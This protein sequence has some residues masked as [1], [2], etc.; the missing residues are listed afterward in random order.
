MKYISE[1][2]LRSLYLLIV[3]MLAGCDYLNEEPLHYLQPGERF[4]EESQME[5]AVHECYYYLPNGYNDVDGSFLDAATNDAVYRI[6]GSGINKLARGEYTSST[7][8]LNIWDR[9]YKGISQTFLVED[10]LHYMNIPKGSSVSDPDVYFETKRKEF[11]SE[12]MMVRAYL[13]FELLRMYGGVP[14]VKRQMELG[15]NIKD[16]QRASFADVVTYIV[17][18]CDKAAEDQPSIINTT[19]GRWGKGAAKAIKAKTLAYAASDL[20][21]KDVKSPLHGYI[22]NNQDAAR[23]AAVEAMDDFMKYTEFGLANNYNMFFWEP[24]NGQFKK[25]YV[26]YKGKPQSNGVESL[27][28]IPS[29]GGN[30][31]IYPTQEFVDAFDNADGSKYVASANLD[32]TQWANRDPRLNNIIIY[33]G[34]K[35]RTNNTIYTYTGTEQTQDGFV[36]VHQKSTRTGY[37]LKKFANYGAVNFDNAVPGVT[38]HIYPIIRYA[39]ILLLYAEMMSELYGP[40]D[41]RQFSM[42]AKKALDD[43]RMRGGIKTALPSNILQDDFRQ[44]VINERRIELCFEDQRYFDLKRWKLGVNILNSPVHGMKIVREGGNYSYQKVVVDEKRKFTQ[45]M[46]FAPIPYDEQLKLD[47]EQNPGW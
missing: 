39:D 5:L 36:V 34:S 46:Y 8:V 47:I 11:G 30:G 32:E 20:Y 43:V 41:A 1:H 33:N 28:F 10:N 21:H 38:H 24:N 25:E 15:E 27:L 4:K 31:G 40:D 9:C 2:S 3:V 26:V 42:T 19:P 35:V 44:R 45:P 37:Y 13:Y 14:L 7:P 29:L 12:A 6:E 23:L 18:L 22:Q 17:G 16:V